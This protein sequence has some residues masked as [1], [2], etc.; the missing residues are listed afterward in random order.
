V[1]KCHR[2]PLLRLGRLQL[3]LRLNSEGHFNLLRADYYFEVLDLDLKMHEYE[4]QYLVLNLYLV[5][6]IFLDQIDLQL[7]IFHQVNASMESS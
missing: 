5:H 4:T 2:D 7:V 6:Q 3:Y 1:G